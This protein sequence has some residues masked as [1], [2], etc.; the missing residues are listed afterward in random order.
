MTA[1]PAAP[2]GPVRI[3]AWLSVCGAPG[4]TRP[5]KPGQPVVKRSG[6]AWRHLNC[7]DPLGNRDRFERGD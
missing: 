4:C 5:I 2:A 1:I 7:S 6:S 3:A